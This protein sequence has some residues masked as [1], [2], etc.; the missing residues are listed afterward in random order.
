M[1]HGPAAGEAP[2]TGTTIV[3]VQYDGGVVIGADSRV[4]TGGQRAAVSLG[5]RHVSPCKALLHC[6]CRYAAAKAVP[7]TFTHGTACLEPHSVCQADSG[8]QKVPLLL[9]HTVT[10]SPQRSGA[11][12]PATLRHPAGTYISNRASDKLTPLTDLVWLLRSGSAADT[13]LVADYGETFGDV[14]PVARLIANPHT[15]SQLMSDS[16]LRCLLAVR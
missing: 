3:A 12:T 9:R 1:A 6:A 13:Q 10:R 2:H 4:S 8:A 5:A 11:V 15:G 14:D 7:C 16:R